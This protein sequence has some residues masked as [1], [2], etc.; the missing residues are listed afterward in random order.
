LEPFELENIP[1]K[2]EELIKGLGNLMQSNESKL[3]EVS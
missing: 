1:Q 2:A 3:P